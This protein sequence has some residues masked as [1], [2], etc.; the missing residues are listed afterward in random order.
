MLQAAWNKNTALA[1]SEKGRQKLKEE[2]GGMFGKEFDS[3]VNDLSEGKVSENAKL[4]LFTELSGSQPITLIDYP[5]PYLQA[6]NGRLFYSLKS[7]GLKQL[8]LINDTIINQAK[9][10]NYAT[11]GKNALAYAAVV[12]LGNATIQET[13]NWMQGREFQIDRVPDNFINYML[14]TAMTSRYSVDRNLTQGNFAGVIAEAVAP[15][16]NVYENLTKDVYG[17]YE[18]YI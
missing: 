16:I 13:K 4:L 9:K 2:W 3:L 14:A 12:G 17:R 5:V 8:E 11:A 6:P 1:K 18:I 10:G 15:P 7:F